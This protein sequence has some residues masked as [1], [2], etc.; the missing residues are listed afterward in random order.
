ME[1]PQGNLCLTAGPPRLHHTLSLV[2]ILIQMTCKTNGQSALRQATYRS[3]AVLEIISRYQNTN[4]SQDMRAE[5]N[6]SVSLAW[7]PRFFLAAQISNLRAHARLIQKLWA[8][9]G[10][11]FVL[12]S[13][14][15]GNTYLDLLSPFRSDS[16]RRA[17]RGRSSPTFGCGH[18]VG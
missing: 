12:L 3:A 9:F 8:D 18:L 14:L 10:L 13:Q 7:R 11:A 6:H 1:L 4:I 17:R 5:A 15:I 16:A 2:G